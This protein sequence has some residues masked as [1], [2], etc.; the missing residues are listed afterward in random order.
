M[1]KLLYVLLLAA[2]LI[3]A[4]CT[5]SAAI[6][7]APPETTEEPKIRAEQVSTFT[8][9][10]FTLG[11]D[12]TYEISAADRILRC[13]EWIRD[14]SVTSVLAVWNQ[15]TWN[16]FFEQLFACGVADWEKEYMPAAQPTDGRQ[17]YLG[18]TGDFAV[19][20]V[21]GNEAFPKTWNDF[22]EIMNFYVFP[23]HKG[24]GEGPSPGEITRTMIDLFLD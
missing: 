6:S 1:K 9:H 7:P 12:E 22:I 8:F 19:I 2:G 15:E 17:W 23:R 3:A 10:Y 14:E 4:L 13:R 24:A 20:S 21:S 18:L 11:I 16:D 5:A